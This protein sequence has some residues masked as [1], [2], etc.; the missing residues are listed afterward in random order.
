[1]I[2]LPGAYSRRYLIG[3]Q[4][5]FCKDFVACLAALRA[6]YIKTNSHQ[7]RLS[8]SRLPARMPTTSWHICNRKKMR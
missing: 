6:A 3:G 7:A 8:D 1:M 2:R 4:S 5:I